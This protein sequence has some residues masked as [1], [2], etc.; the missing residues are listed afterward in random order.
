MKNKPKIEL[1]EKEQREIGMFVAQRI[2]ENC[3][4]NLSKTDEE[5]IEKEIDALI[6]EKL[7]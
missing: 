6:G 7:Q 5:E 2:Y 3:D 4:K 1:S